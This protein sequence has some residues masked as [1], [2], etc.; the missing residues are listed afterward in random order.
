MSRII[1]E[2][3]KAE[4]EKKGWSLDDL[5]KRSKIHRQ[6]IHR[7]E[8]GRL[9][10][11]RETVIEKLARALGIT[12][13]TL[14]NAEIP[15]HAES[16]AN[17]VDELFSSSQIN[18]RVSN[19]A[20]NA[21]SLAAN[22]YRVTHAQ[23]VEIAPLLFCWAAEQSLKQ[24]REGLAAINRAN[25]ELE[26]LGQPHLHAA[27]FANQR[28]E[29]PL[30]AERQSIIENDL[31]G[32][33]FD[34]EGYESHLPDDYDE[35]ANNPFAV[36]LRGMTEELGDLA[37]FTEWDP[38]SSPEYILCRS[39]AV[40]Y[41]GGDNEAADEILDGSV[42][43]HKLPKDLREKGKGEA[44]AKWVRDEAVA[45]REKLFGPINIDDLDV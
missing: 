4:R 18:L 29:G 10:H 33:L 7:I 34:D 2:I 23:I 5:A 35:A 43:L 27:T 39:K 37:T 16:A 24:R 12:E 14:T 38:N 41:V 21:L 11:N 30:H 28:S 13:D 20:R 8:M 31:F 26:Q 44:R 3:L 9:K 32:K 42:P 36:F 1:P 45:R 25:H 22:R 17:Y 15:K 6:S 19:R 40:E